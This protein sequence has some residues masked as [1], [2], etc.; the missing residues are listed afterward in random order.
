MN[1]EKRAERLVD[2]IVELRNLENPTLEDF[3]HIKRLAKTLGEIYSRPETPSVEFKIVLIDGLKSIYTFNKDKKLPIYCA[4]ERAFR[5]RIPLKVSST[6]ERAELASDKLSIR[7]DSDKVEKLFT[8]LINDYQFKTL[9]QMSIADEFIEPDFSNCNWES[10]TQTRILFTY[11]RNIG[12]K[13]CDKMYQCE[14]E[15]DEYWENYN[16]TVDYYCRSDA[17]MPNMG[18]KREIDHLELKKMVW[19]ITDEKILQVFGH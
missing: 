16:K 17:I 5:K 15:S 3:N 4:A 18:V 12:N 2:K 10:Y 8:E 19:K 13:Y 6:N 1:K 9:T 11:L 7:T 14:S